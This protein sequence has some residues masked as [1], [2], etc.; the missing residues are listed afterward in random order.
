VLFDAEW[1]LPPVADPETPGSPPAY[2]TNFWGHH[3][4]I[5]NQED[6]MTEAQGPVAEYNEALIRQTQEEIDKIT[7]EVRNAFRAVGAV[8]AAKKELTKEINELELKTT[9]AM[10]RMRILS[11]EMTEAVAKMAQEAHR[12]EAAISTQMRYEDAE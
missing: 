8:T 7:I 2:R 3:Y 6:D 10:V 5:I 9:D 4:P 12:L 1:P 11:L